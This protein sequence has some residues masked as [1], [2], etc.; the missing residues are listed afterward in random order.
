MSN[1]IVSKQDAD[2]IIR[3]SYD[4]A[5]RALKMLPVGG[6]LVPDK[7]TSIVLTYIVAGN[8]AGQIGTVTY[9][10]DVVQVALLT[11]T[12]DVSDRLIQ[13]VRT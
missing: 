8:G 11:L 10:N 7:Y 13:V 3:L 6:N 9:F 1:I 2:Q 4:D 5:T 12:Y